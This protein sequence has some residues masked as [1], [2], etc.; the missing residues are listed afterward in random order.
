MNHFIKHSAV[1]LFIYIYIYI[2]CDVNSHLKR[3][4]DASVIEEVVTNDQ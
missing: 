4:N 3:T 1:K 2:I